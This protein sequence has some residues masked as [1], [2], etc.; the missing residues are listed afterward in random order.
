MKREKIKWKLFF[1]LFFFVWFYSIPL[2]ILSYG[3]MKA[4]HLHNLLDMLKGKSL[5]KILFLAITAPVLEEFL[6]RLLLKPS[7]KN[8]VWYVSFFSAVFIFDL[9]LG[10]TKGM[11]FLAGLLLVP[12]ILLVKRNGLKRFQKWFLKHFRLFFYLSCLLFGMLHI[13]N[14]S[15]LSWSLL[16]WGPLL[17]LPQL[18]AGLVLGYIRM[19]FG[20]VYSIL[21]HFSYNMLFLFPIILGKI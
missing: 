21:F 3:L 7:V 14:F 6:F 13:G 8:L 1:F 2:N 17:V 11:I 18:F 4:L 20:I 9:L 5:L 15:P 12:A 19:R 10:K 16:F